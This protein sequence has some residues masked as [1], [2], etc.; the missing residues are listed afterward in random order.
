MVIV[1]SSGD[2]SVRKERRILIS[3]RAVLLG[4][5]SAACSTL[6]KPALGLRLCPAPDTAP[7]LC[8]A[9]IDPQRFLGQQTVRLQRQSQWCWAASISMICTWY[10]YHVE[11][12]SVVE[13]IF[14][15]LKNM[16]GDDRVLTSALNEDWEDDDGRRFHISAAVFSPMLGR[17]DVNNARV[18]DDLRNDRPLINGSRA[19][20]TVVARVD[21]VPGPGGQP[22]VRRVHVIDPFP[23]AAP[24]PLFARILDQDEMTPVSLRGSL[25]YLA[26]IK[27]TSV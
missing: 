5:T 6:A 21:Y 22:Q 4:G 16:P 24:P 26:S 20:A 15:G 17:N 18:V 25:R 11:Q 13:R 3:R 27:V 1:A 9:M 14:G 7:G 8:S 10:G 23:G 2:D 19:H 12:E